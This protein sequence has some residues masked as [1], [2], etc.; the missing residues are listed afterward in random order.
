MIDILII[1]LCNT[2]LP[3]H[4]RLMISRWRLLSFE[5]DSIWCGWNPNIIILMVL[6]MH[7]EII[8]LF[9]VD[10]AIILL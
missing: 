9:L 7:H 5:D 8:V 4:Q 1:I 10:R 6:G 2:M 3:Q